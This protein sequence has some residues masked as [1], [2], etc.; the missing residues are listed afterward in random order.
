VLHAPWP[1]ADPKALVDQSSTYVVQI[2][3]KKRALITVTQTL[4]QSEL[5][6]LACQHP[7]VSKHLLEKKIKKSIVVPKK[8]INLVV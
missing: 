2:N 1:Q 6:A 3:G 5:I 8:L 7:L 4:S